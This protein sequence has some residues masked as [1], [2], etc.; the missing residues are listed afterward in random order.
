MY[1]TEKSSFWKQSR[2]INFQANLPLFNCFT[3]RFFTALRIARGGPEKLI[4]RNRK[5]AR[6]SRLR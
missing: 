3:L 6:N 1:S 2:I 5:R 4:V